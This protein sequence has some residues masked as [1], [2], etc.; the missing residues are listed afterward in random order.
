MFEQLLTVLQQRG[1]VKAGGKQRTGST[2]I[3]AAVRTLSRLELVGETLR[4]ALEALAVV[5]PDWLR[6]Q[7]DRK[8]LKRYGQPFDDGRLP[9]TTADKQA[10]AKQIGRDGAQLLTAIW[11]KPELVELRQL[12]AVDIL[13]QVWIQQY[14]WQDE[15]LRWRAEAD[16]PPATLRILSPYD[17]EARGAKKRNQ[18]WFGYRVY[19]TETCDEDQ[20]RLIADVQTTLAPSQDYNATP[21]IQQALTQRQLLPSEQFADAAYVSGHLLVTAREEFGLDLV[22]PVMPDTSWQAAAGQ[23]FDLANF[24][25]DWANQQAICPAGKSSIYWHPTLDRSQKPVIT[26]RFSGK[27]CQHCQYRPQCTQA[28]AHGRFMHLRPQK[29]HE[30]IQQ[31]RAYQQTDEFKE[32]YK[33]RAGIEGTM[34]QSAVALGMRRSRFR[35]LAKTRLQH[36]V[37]A[38]AINL[39][40]AVNWLSDVPLAKTRQSHFAALMA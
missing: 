19:L 24:Q 31:A 10:L 9:K 13:R 32:R 23:D 3:L 39:K 36:L 21:V 34:S 4:Q 40:R 1:L 8:W 20:P 37:T 16:T 25:I 38:A 27:D 7:V 15:Q 26:V 5:A 30:A 11:S 12:A 33:I 14:Y 29:E 6:Q 28:K 18:A 22:G 35:G 17:L 2:H